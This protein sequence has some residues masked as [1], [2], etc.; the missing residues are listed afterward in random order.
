[1][2]ELLDAEDVARDALHDPRPL[3]AMGRCGRRF[4]TEVHGG[5]LCWSGGRA[6]P[7][8]PGAGAQDRVARLR[9]ERRCTLERLRSL[10]QARA[11]RGHGARSRD[12]SEAQ[13]R[14]S[15]RGQ[16][17]RAGCPAGRSAVPALPGVRRLPLPG[18]R[19]RGADRGEGRPGRGRAPPDRPARR[20]AARADRPRRVRLSLSE[21][22]R[23][24]VHPDP[25]GRGPWLPPRR[26]LG[27]SSRHPPLLADDRPR[28]LD[29]GSD[30]RLGA[31]PGARGLRSGRAHGL[32]APPRRARGPQHR[33]GARPA[34]H[35]TRQARR[36]KLRRRT[37]PSSPRSGRSTGR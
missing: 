21:Q 30:A 7:T 6:R 11:A 9:R 15:A 1:M 32:P 36:R 28:Q 25:G 37:H 29:P 18:P 26:A 12:Q 27:R 2:R 4:E 20:S 33:P 22:A 8:R 19:V 3:L 35:G 5:T 34:R 24:L 16:G 13:S 14:G 23:V 10:R 31:R 17:R